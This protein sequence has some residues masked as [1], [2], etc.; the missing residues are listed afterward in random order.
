MISQR[1]EHIVSQSRHHLAHLHSDSL[2]LLNHLCCF[3]FL[4]NLPCCLCLH[5]DD[6]LVV[7]LYLL[8]LHCLLYHMLHLSMLHL[9]IYLFLPFVVLIQLYILFLVFHNLVLFQMVVNLL[10]DFQEYLLCQILL[11]F[12]LDH[13][14][15]CMYSYYFLLDLLKILWYL[16]NIL[17]LLVIDLLFDLHILIFLLHYI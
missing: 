7:S 8:L 6:F 5:L 13:M 11:Y 9:L 16:E 10:L 4:Y 14:S 2:Y 15:H 1:F 17:D 3:H 12:L